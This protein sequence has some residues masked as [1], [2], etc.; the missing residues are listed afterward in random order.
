M[1]ADACDQI[2][3]AMTVVAR[4]DALIID[5]RKNN[6][7]GETANVITGYLLDGEQPLTGE[8]KRPNDETRA[9]SSPAWVPGRLFGGRSAGL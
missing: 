6:E 8:Y 5:L 2:A 1:F 7:G 9:S 4:G 3:T